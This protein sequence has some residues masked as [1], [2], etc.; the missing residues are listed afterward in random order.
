M[1]TKNTG[2][3]LGNCIKKIEVLNSK[4]NHQC[5]IVENTKKHFDDVKKIIL[6]IMSDLDVLTIKINIPAYGQA[7]QG[8]LLEWLNNKCKT[9]PNFEFSRDKIEAPKNGDIFFF[10]GPIRLANGGK[11]SNSC[12]KF[13]LFL[14]LRETFA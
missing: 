7:I 14:S 6:D 8:D 12:Y 13:E 4:I 5:I 2:I 3:I 10:F 11:R 1:K 9:R